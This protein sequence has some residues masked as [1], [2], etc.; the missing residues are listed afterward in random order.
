MRR[1]LQAHTAAWAESLPDVTKPQYAVLL[2]VSANPDIEQA[3]VGELAAIDKATLA[4][5][6]TRLED[7]GLITRESDPSDRRKRTIRLTEDGVAT[8]RRTRPLAAEVDAGLVT[9][10]TA[11]EQR[12]LQNLLHK[13]AD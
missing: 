3:R 5:M 1:V 4:G 12:I 6:L 8:L 11:E 2:A 9:A 7:R 10:L 13:L